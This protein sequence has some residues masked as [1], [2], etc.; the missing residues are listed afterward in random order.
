[1]SNHDFFEHITGVGDMDAVSA[2]FGTLVSAFLANNSAPF[3]ES[4]VASVMM[5]FCGARIA[6]LEDFASTENSVPV[7]HVSPGSEGERAQLAHSVRHPGKS[8]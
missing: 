3:C 6:R 2:T 8:A 5:M 7:S 1:M 4:F